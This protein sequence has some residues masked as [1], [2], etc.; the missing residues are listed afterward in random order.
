MGGISTADYANRLASG[1]TRDQRTQYAQGRIE[2]WIM[3]S[4]KLAREKAYIDGGVSIPI[5]KWRPSAS[6]LGKPT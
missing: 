1:L 5:E 3:E 2:D 6:A 4:Q